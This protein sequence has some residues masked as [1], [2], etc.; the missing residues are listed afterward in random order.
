MKQ[1]LSPLLLLLFLL[2]GNAALASENEEIQY[3]LSFIGASDCIFIRNGD[4]HPSKEASEHLEMKYNHV[5]KRIQTA[6]DFID[7]IASKSSLSRRQY[8]VRC[9]EV[10]FP[11]KRWLEEALVSHRTSTGKQKIPPKKP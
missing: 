5:K 3:L 6:E 8:T 2:S 7:K 4:E 1:L 10:I 9:N 11:T